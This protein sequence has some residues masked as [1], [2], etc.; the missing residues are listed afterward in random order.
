MHGG[1]THFPIALVMASALFDLAG[2]LVPENP[3][4]TRRAGLHAAGCY[5]LILG[6]L[7]A[8]GAVASGLIMSHWQLWGHGNLLRHHTFLWPAF[9]LLIGLAVWRALVGSHASQRTFKIYLGVTL[10]AAAFMG[11]AGYWGGELLNTNS[12]HRTLNIEH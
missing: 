8:L 7:G 1:T 9:G 6:A 12:Q 10:I 4:K 3:G 11:A 5:T 2:F